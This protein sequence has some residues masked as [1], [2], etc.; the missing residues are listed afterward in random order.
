LQVAEGE[1]DLDAVE[2]A[3]E[4]DLVRLAGEA[5]EERLGVLLCRGNLTALKL[6]PGEQQQREREV[7]LHATALKVRRGKP[8]VLEALLR[9]QQGWQG[10]S[11]A[12]C[13]SDEIL[14]A[15]LLR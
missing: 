11:R 7:V 9:I 13:L 5:S 1:I 4:V 14:I 3:E 6:G 15:G 12:L 2:V 10:A 8:Q